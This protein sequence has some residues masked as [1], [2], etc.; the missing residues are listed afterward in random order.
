LAGFFAW[1]I[2]WQGR[3]ASGLGYLLVR[4]AL[5]MVAGGLGGALARA[6]R[7]RDAALGTLEAGRFRRAFAVQMAL[8]GGFGVVALVL[9]EVGGLPSVGNGGDAAMVALYAFLAGWSEPFVLNVLHR[10]APD[11]GSRPNSAVS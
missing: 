6:L 9:V 11:E 10:L 1:A 4:S 7:L 8:G 5:A 3:S 2:Y